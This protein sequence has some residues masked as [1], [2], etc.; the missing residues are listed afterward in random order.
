M[1]KIEIPKIGT[2]SNVELGYP[3]AQSRFKWAEFKNRFAK[4]PICRTLFCPSASNC[5]ETHQK[6]P[7]KIKLR[8]SES[9]AQRDV[10]SSQLLNPGATPAPGIFLS[11]TGL[12]PLLRAQLA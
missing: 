6:C 10:K 2:S 5:S 12:G 8:R 11:E 1:E 7:L 3:G 4:G 9:N